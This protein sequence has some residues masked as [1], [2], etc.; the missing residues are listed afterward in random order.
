MRRSA[1]LLLAAVS[2]AAAYAAV[3]PR[4]GGV[5]R[6]ELRAAP[7]TPETADGNLGALLASGAF[8]VSQWDA[9]RRAV[10]VANEQYQGG[11][12]FVDSIEV[13]MGRS[14][15]DQMVDFELGKAHVVEVDPAE[16]P[17][18]SQRGLRIWSSPPNE[19]LALVFTGGAD[20]PRVREALA[21]SIDR[22]AIHTVLLGRQGA[23]AGG[24]LPH[25]LSGYAFLFPTARD[26]P[27]AQKALGPTRSAPLT[28]EYDSS[29][30]TLRA[31][32][33]RLALNAR[34]A[35]LT[36]RI[37]PQGGE[38]RLVRRRIPDVNP[39]RAL[40][41]LAESLGLEGRLPPGDPYASERALVESRWIIPLAH[42]PEIYGL[43]PHVRDWAGWDLPR[44]WL[45]ASAP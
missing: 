26:L 33:E 34:E 11:R 24:L 23:P 18:A 45:D 43:S 37:A 12:P 4:Y 13:E 35:G 8:R 28:L 15:R 22:T 21:L 36:L 3:R 27:R 6:V 20:N 9:N 19:L 25:W 38:V 39:A 17:R 42:L 29:D 14:F 32:A 16:A 44:V 2:L 5:L 40:T 10:L 30:T 7:Q 1:C 41:A 31:V